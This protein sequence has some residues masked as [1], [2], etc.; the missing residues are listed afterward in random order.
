ML[1]EH[2]VRPYGK[3]SLRKGTGI[4]AAKFRWQKGSR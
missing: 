4:R 1:D 2:K 3:I